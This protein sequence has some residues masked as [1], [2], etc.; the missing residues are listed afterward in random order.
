MRTTGR[1]TIV[2]CL[3]LTLGLPVCGAW[4]AARYGG[5][6]RRVAEVSRPGLAF[7]QF[8]VDLGPV[9]PTDEIYARFGFTNTGRTPVKITR[10][11]PSCGCVKPS[12]KKTEYDAMDSGEF[13]LRV[14]TAGEAPGDREYRLLVR[15]TDPEP[16]ET[17]L[18]FRAK[19]PERQ[20]FVRPRAVMVYQNGLSPTV[21]EVTVTDLRGNELR[22]LDTK[23]STPLASAEILEPSAAPDGTLEHKVRVTVAADVPQGTSWGTITLFTNDSEFSELTVP[24]KIVG[25]TGVSRGPMAESDRPGAVRPH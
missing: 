13:Y 1:T 17:T 16:R 6:P 9:E 2:S 20:V 14:R 10:W 23:S 5:T 8:L 22:L 18:V 7:D 12:L 3:A 21:Q 15:Y 25:P 4:G 11:E 24:L 19:L